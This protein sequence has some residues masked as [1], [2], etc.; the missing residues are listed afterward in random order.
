MRATRK[1][2]KRKRRKSSI[3]K[4][5]KRKKSSVRRK[6]KKNKSTLRKEANR[7]K[8]SLR[9]QIKNKRSSLRK[10]VKKKRKRYLKKKGDKKNLKKSLISILTKIDNFSKKK[11]VNNKDL[12]IANLV[13]LHKPSPGTKTFH[14]EH[15]TVHQTADNKKEVM[16]HIIK[17]AY[18]PNKKYFIM[19]H[20]SWCPHCTDALPQF[21][22]AEQQVKNDKNLKT[23]NMQEY[24]CEEN[25]ELKGQAEGFPTMFYVENKQKE[26]YNGGRSTQD[27][28][29]FIKS[30]M[31]SS[32]SQM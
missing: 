6:I 19:L 8:S 16:K 2:V 23:I 5:I 25:P 22:E 31:S 30:K 10:K 27:I 9:K 28:I 4:H 21:K 7:K 3:Q 29:N 13:N 15:E 20:V 17:G 18:N 32:R 26:Q 12:S 14:K 24:E 11:P 1:P